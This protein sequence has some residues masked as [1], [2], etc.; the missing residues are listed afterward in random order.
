MAGKYY[1]K[2]AVTGEYIAKDRGKTK[3]I[4]EAQCIDDSKRW[5]SDHFLMLLARSLK[6]KDPY[7]YERED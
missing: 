4:E 1:I 6:M 2:D 3:N 5:N 7:I